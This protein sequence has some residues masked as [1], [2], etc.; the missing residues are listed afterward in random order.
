MPNGLKLWMETNKSV[1]NENQW[2]GGSAFR[3][4]IYLL[5]LAVSG[6]SCGMRDLSLWHIG[7]SLVVAQG[8]SCSQACG[9]L[10]PRPGNLRP[11]NW[12][13]ESCFFFFF[14]IYFWLHWVFV[15]V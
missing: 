13:V 11:L 12:K 3:F 4:Y 1:Y 5:F 9:I 10:V 7:F 2:Q 6:L 15:A 8:L 14:F